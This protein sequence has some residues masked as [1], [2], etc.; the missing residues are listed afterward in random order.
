MPVRETAAV[1]APATAGAQ[2]RTTRPSVLGSCFRRSTALLLAPL[3]ACA[4]TTPPAVTGAVPASPPAG[5]QYLYG[6][7][8]GAALSVQAWHGLL[9]YVAGK[10]KARPAD[11]VVL[12]Q[13][14]SLDAPT[15]V[16]CG[17]KPLAAVFDVDETVLLNIGYEYHD[18]TTG[19]GYSAADWD[20]WERPGRARSRRCRAR[21]MCWPRCARW[22]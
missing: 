4:T 14:A 6:S 12:A 10:M 13:G 15:F 17:D 11:S 3:A 8:E 16:P 9:G 19:K 7:G 1:S 21:T 22:A 2:G 18:A 20:A 5:M